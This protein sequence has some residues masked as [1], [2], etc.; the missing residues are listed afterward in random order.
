MYTENIYRITAM[1]LLLSA[2]SISSLSAI[3]QRKV[4]R[5]SK[6]RRREVN[7]GAPQGFWLA[8]L[9][10]CLHLPDQPGLDGTATTAPGFLDSLDGSCPDGL[11]RSPSDW[12]IFQPGEKRYPNGCHPPEAYVGGAWSISLDQA[13]AIHRWIPVIHRS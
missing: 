9:A 12:G 5:Q 1:V 10:E 3:G 7:L 8:R 11:L 13:P 6:A 4:V 2:V